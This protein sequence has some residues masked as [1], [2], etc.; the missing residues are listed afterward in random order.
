[1]F[2]ENLGKYLT[3]YQH[4]WCDNLVPRRYVHFERFLMLMD[5]SHHFRFRHGYCKS[6]PRKMVQ[7]WAEKEMRNL[8]RFVLYASFLLPNFCKNQIIFTGKSLPPNFRWLSSLDM[9]W[10]RKSSRI[11]ELPDPLQWF[12][13]VKQALL[14]CCDNFLNVYY[15]QLNILHNFLNVYY[16][17]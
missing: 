17:Q 13:D 2:P 4:R 14:C 16:W 8:Q 15:W 10:F 12:V 11:N 9:F 5:D 3:D 6:N 7:T 1:M